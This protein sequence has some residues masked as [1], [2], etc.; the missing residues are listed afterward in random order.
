MTDKLLH[1]PDGVRDIYGIECENK[2]YVKECMKNVLKLNGFKFIQTPSFEFFDIF[3]KERG[4]VPSREMYKFFDR[5]GNT[6]ALRPDITPS[7]ARCV[8]KYYKDNTLPIR[9]SY[10][11]N[12]FINNSSYQGKLKEYTQVG[13]EL[14]N[15][16]STDAD[17]QMIAV[18]IE[19]LLA[20][21]LKEFQIELG[22]A[23]LFL[24]L[25]EQT[26]LD[27]DDVMELKILID[28]KNIF[29]ATSLM[30]N[31]DV[32]E[33]IKNTI[34]SLPALFGGYDTIE[35]ARKIVKSNK[36]IEALD[37]LDKI[38]SIL[39][40]YGYSD[41]VSFDLGMLSRYDYYTGIIMKG[42]TYGTGD[43]IVSGGRYDKLLAQFGKEA[44]AIGVAVLLD[45]LLIAM[46]RQ[47]IDIDN[48]NHDELVIFERQGRAKAIEHAK[49]LRE[50]GIC[51]ELIRKSERHQ[52]EE[53]LEN[54]K[55]NNCEKVFFINN[56]NEIQTFDI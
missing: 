34:L 28:E 55:K 44:P 16:D 12:T 33:N 10:V 24:G 7:V 4:T 3:N 49:K 35:K 15:D 46:Q 6:M 29:G 37:R 52:L 39:C 11:G 32:D 14:I 42:Y 23:D 41:Y 9:L 47:N 2:E 36:G 31:K 1:T 45:Q 22:H 21:G 56:N 48:I 43:A 20:A 26:N 27:S 13:M 30:E 51:V 25:L 38:Y 18:T 54:A 40:G 17:A 8:A 53:Y 19:C 5:D 50:S